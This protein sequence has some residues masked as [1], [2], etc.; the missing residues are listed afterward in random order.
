MG[1][2]GPI[3]VSIGD[4]N[5]LNTFLDAN[6]WMPKSQMFVDDYSFDAYKAAGFSRFDQVDKES[7]AVKNFKMTAPE[8]GFKEW[9]NYFGVVSKV[10]PLPKDMKFG[11]V[12]EGVLWT[13]GTFVVQGDDVVYQWTDTI[14]G[15][16]PVIEEVVSIAKDAA[17]T[18]K[19]KGRF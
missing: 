19:G 6:P 4:A 17:M 7:D 2:G 11:Q 15:N 10:S 16:H 12:P 14:P 3:F 13:G 1:I 8:L 9:M 18:T 5:K